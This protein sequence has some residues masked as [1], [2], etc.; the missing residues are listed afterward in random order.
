M[1]YDDGHVTA[2]IEVKRA[3]FGDALK[4]SQEIRSVKQL[5]GEDED[6]AYTRAVVQSTL[7]Y[8]TASAKI[9]AVTPSQPVGD[10]LYD[11]ALLDLPADLVEAW[12]EEVYKVNP[13][14]NPQRTFEPEASEKKASTSIV[15]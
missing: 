3:T 2:E 7:R 11:A 14:W 8:G 12:L 10:D 15:A 4:R 1:H 13:M 5:N 6:A 9:E